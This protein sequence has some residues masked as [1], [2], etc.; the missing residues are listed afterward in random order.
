[1]TP[2]QA[3]SPVRLEATNAVEALVIG[4]DNLETPFYAAMASSFIKQILGA[5]EYERASED[6]RKAS[7]DLGRI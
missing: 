6:F 2:A 3:V 1:V 7:D 5:D 4:S